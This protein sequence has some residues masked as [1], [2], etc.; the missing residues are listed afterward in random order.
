MVYRPQQGASTSLETTK[1]WD[2]FPRNGL[3]EQKQVERYSTN[4]I[5]TSYRAG[6]YHYS[7]A[8]HS[9]LSYLFQKSVVRL[10]IDLFYS[11]NHKFI[12]EHSNAHFRIQTNKIHLSYRMTFFDKY[13]MNQ[14]HCFQWINVSKISRRKRSFLPKN[15]SSSFDKYKLRHWTKLPISGENIRKETIILALN[16]QIIHCHFYP[17]FQQ[18]TRS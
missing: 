17:L 14:I 16:F 4:L 3:D 7:W 18:I 12:G 13:K 6:C 1:L 9:F 11:I 2:F 5:K 15:S 10:P 8:S